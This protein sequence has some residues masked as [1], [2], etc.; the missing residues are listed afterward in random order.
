MLR[1]VYNRPNTTLLD[2][3]ARYSGEDKEPKDRLSTLK[4]LMC[5]SGMKKSTFFC[6]LWCLLALI[7]LAFTLW[8]FWYFHKP[9][10]VIKFNQD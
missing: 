5:L 2:L 3:G 10:V 9:L 8:A 7:I 4:R 1:A 6:L